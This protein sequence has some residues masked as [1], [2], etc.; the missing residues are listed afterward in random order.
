MTVTSVKVAITK[1]ITF[2]MY[3]CMVD[4]DACKGEIA[5]MQGILHVRVHTHMQSNVSLGMEW[6][7]NG[8][9]IMKHTIYIRIS[10]IIT[11]DV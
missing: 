3:G 8:L 5:L 2:G 10:L 9:Y 4:S 11:I 6:K 7:N 1:L